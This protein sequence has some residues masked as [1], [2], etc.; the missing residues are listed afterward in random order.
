M[1]KSQLSAYESCLKLGIPKAPAPMDG[2][3]TGFY[4][5]PL[6]FDPET[7]QRSYATTAFYFPNKERPN[8]SVLT[9]AHV[10]K[11]VTKSTDGALRAEVVEFIHGGQQHV[12]KVGREVVLCAGYV[13]TIFPLNQ[14]TLVSHDT[15]VPPSLLNYLSYR[16]LVVKKCYNPSEYL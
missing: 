9:G 16:E 10:T 13:Y 3:P 14:P 1:A 6:S 12:V 11:L 4:F 7:Y 2:D 8:F 15:L 5:C